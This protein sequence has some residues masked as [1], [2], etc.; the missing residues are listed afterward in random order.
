MNETLTV[1]DT[2]KLYDTEFEAV[3][4]AQK[5]ED[6]FGEEMV[7]YKC[8]PHAHYHLTHKNRKARRGVG[9]AFIKCEDCG[10][11][12]K[13]SKMDKHKGKCKW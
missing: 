4:A 7:P 6:K 13:R 8:W 9:K 12:M 5:L 1:C 3:I 2:K 10:R 11:I